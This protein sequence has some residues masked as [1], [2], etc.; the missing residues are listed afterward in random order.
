LEFLINFVVVKDEIHDV[1]A[2][3]QDFSSCGYKKQ[4]LKP[5]YYDLYITI[6]W[7][8]VILVPSLYYLSCFLW[9]S[10]L[11]AKIVFVSLMFTSKKK[12]VNYLNTPCCCFVILISV[13]FCFV[14][15]VNFLMNKIVSYSDVAHGSKFGL[16]PKGSP[17][18]KTTHQ[19]QAAKS[20]E[21]IK[22]EE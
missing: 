13:L 9:N 17:Q 6:S 19:Q 16:S 22:K 5:D 8:I 14:F 1:F 12:E 10:S 18:S 3:E 2:R 11:F 21:N 7:I 4:D 20:V 15:V